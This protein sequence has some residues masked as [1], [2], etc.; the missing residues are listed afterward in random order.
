MNKFLGAAAALVVLGLAAPAFAQSNTS[1]D[2]ANVSALVLKAIKVTKTN[3]LNFGTVVAPNSGSGTAVMSTDGNN[4][5]TG[6]GGVVVLTSGATKQAATFTI[7]AE[8]SAAYTVS[9]NGGVNTVTLTKQSGSGDAN[10]TLTLA[11]SALPNAGTNSAQP[12]VVGGSLAVASTTGGTYTGTFTLAAT[13][14]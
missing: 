6:N 10:A 8:N 7:N 13:Y 11:T 12:V 5:V 9:V 4:T 2:T 1:S 14:N 3:D